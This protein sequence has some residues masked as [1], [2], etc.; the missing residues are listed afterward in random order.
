MPLVLLSINNTF[1]WLIKNKV[2]IL[3]TSICAKQDHF[4]VDFKKASAIIFGTEAF[5]LSPKWL[6]KETT[7]IRIPMI[8]G[9]D[10]LNVSVSVGIIVY[11]AIRQRAKL[12][13]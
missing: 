10:S 8:S 5:G 11:E 13:N 6:E 4:A 2:Q 7:Q 3:S 12:K 1:K 9:V